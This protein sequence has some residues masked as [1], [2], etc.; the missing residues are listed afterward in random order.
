MMRRTAITFLFFILLSSSAYA[1]DCGGDT[2]CLCGD[3]VVAS[4]TLTEADLVASVGCHSN[5]LY[6]N[7]T[8]VVLD[9]GGL[10]IEGPGVYDGIRVEAAGVEVRNCS[11]RNFRNGIFLKAANQSKVISN[12]VWDNSRSG[13]FLNNSIGVLVQ[14][15]IADGNN[16][17]VGIYS[18]GGRGSIF[19]GNSASNNGR[20]LAIASTYDVQANNNTAS[21]NERYG[22]YLFSTTLS[23]LAD[24][25]VEKNGLYGIYLLKDSDEN[26]LDR[27][28]VW[29]NLEAGLYLDPTSDYRITLI[30][31]AFCRNSN[32]DILVDSPDTP[33]G[34]KNTCNSPG[35]WND[36]GQSNCT[37]R[38]TPGDGAISDC[39]DGTPSG[40]CSSDMPLYCDEGILRYNCT[41]CGCPIG[42]SCDKNG[43]GGCYV[44][45]IYNCSDGTRYGHCALKK[46]VFCQD[47]ELVDNCD[48]CGCPPGY[49]CNTSSGHCF[50]VDVCQD[51]TFYGACSSNVSYMCKSGRLVQN[52]TLCGCPEDMECNST[53]ERCYLVSCI[54]DQDCPGGY[55]SGP[56]CRDREALGEACARD[57]A[58]SSGHCVGGTCVSCVSD[59]ECPTT[60]VCSE[61]SCRAVSCPNGIVR[62]HK[63]F[64]F[65]CESDQ[66]CQAHQECVNRY[67]SALFCLEDQMIV[68]HECVQRPF[69][70]YDYAFYMLIGLAAVIAIASAH[71]YRSRGRK[72]GGPQAGEKEEEE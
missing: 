60:E 52:C 68:D 51:G 32:H 59:S 27:N 13:I 69:T 66:D 23:T 8:G 24:N 65:D 1:A 56:Y 26:R 71:L 39:F 64:P 37:Y 22:I 53:S 48:L 9:C 6:I 49:G 34:S 14:D 46:P 4:R 50:M 72:E 67:C 62:Q 42:Q 41:I 63:C 35:D 70:L 61:G 29:G 58:C 55:C 36:A 45:S 11:I 18:I 12:T 16:D 20:G 19:E 43:T 57:A 38:C 44:E 25:T 33:Y 54:S 10:M 40:V 5:G 17:G 21:R 28:Q 15:N 7:T 3:R 31:N 30:E 47:G 2:P